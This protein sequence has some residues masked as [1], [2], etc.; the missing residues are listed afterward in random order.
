MRAERDPM[1]WMDA[2][3]PAL[4]GEER[5]DEAPRAEAAQASRAPDPEVVAKPTRRQFTAE[6]R[7]RIL[8]EADRCTR[9]GEVG[10]LLRREGLCVFRSKPIT[11]SSPNR[12]LIPFQADHPFQSM[13][14]TFWLAT[15][16]V[17]GV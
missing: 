3:A 1:T 5:S 10:R 9:P 17:G 6:Y 7:L 15:G 12:S 11:H 13:P 4:G 16:T 8:E 2:D 14:I